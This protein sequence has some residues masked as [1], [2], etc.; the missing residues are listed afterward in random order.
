VTMWM[1]KRGNINSNVVIH[2]TDRREGAD[3]G[4]SN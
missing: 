2:Q 1:K 3:H 4:R